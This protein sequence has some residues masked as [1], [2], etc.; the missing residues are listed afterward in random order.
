MSRS[1]KRNIDEL[2]EL[3]AENR[4]LKAVIKS[5]Q[6]QLRKIEKEFKTDFTQDEN[7]NEDLHSHVPRCKICNKGKLKEVALGEF[8]TIISCTICDHK[9]VKKHG[10]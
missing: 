10:S 6:R 2:E 3:R 9:I 7:K 5:L 1:K 8:R 4:E